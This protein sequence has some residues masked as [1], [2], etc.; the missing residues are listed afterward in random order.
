MKLCKYSHIRH[1]TGPPELRAA[2]YVAAPGGSRAWF[3]SDE[4]G[5]R[6]AEELNETLQWLR[7][8]GETSVPQVWTIAY[9]T[10]LR[11]DPAV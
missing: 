8:R 5:E 11:K 10:A 6:G 1:P 3:G 2:G 7:D 9:W 4:D